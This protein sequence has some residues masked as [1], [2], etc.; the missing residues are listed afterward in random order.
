MELDVFL[1]ANPFER[2]A[3]QYAISLECRDMLKLLSVDQE[4]KMTDTL[5]TV[6]RQLGVANLPSMQETGRCEVLLTYIGKSLTDCRHHIKNKVTE[7]LKAGCKSAKDIGSLTAAITS[8]SKVR[9]T[10]ALYMRIAAV[11]WVAKEYSQCTE[12]AF[13]VKFDEKLIEWRQRAQTPALIQALFQE[14]YNSDKDTFGLPDLLA[15]PT[16]N[17][18]H[19]EEWITSLNTFASRPTS[20][21]VVPASSRRRTKRS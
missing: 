1:V 19:Q 21:A 13:W 20:S 16:L 15:H 9:P 11:R 7:T 4:Y 3:Q 18:N 5:K 10:A 12:D 17:P 14:M 8:R 6:M 2:E